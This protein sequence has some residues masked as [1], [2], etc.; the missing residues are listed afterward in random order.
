[1]AKAALTRHQ[2]RPLPADFSQEA[3]VAG[4]NMLSGLIMGSRLTP[5]GGVAQRTIIEMTARKFRTR[6]NIHRGKVRRKA[7]T[8]TAKAKAKARE[9]GAKPGP[10]IMRRTQVMPSSG[11]VDVFPCT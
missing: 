9:S 11:H 2:W 3:L 4:R 1:M 5:A 10:L 7:G 8:V 6:A